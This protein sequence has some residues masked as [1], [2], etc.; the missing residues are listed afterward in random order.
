M[1]LCFEQG[2]SNIDNL[3]LLEIDGGTFWGV[4]GGVATVIGG[5]A[6]VVGG[7]ALLLIPEPTTGTKFAG[8]AAVIGGLAAM[9]GGAASIAQNIK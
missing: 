2:F 8:G 6:A 4:V 5:A 1:E 7:A 9:A 3:D